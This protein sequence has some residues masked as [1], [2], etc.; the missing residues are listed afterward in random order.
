MDILLEL[1]TTFWQWSVVIVLILIGFIISWFDGQG[2][3]CRFKN[4]L[5]MPYYNL[6]Q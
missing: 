5:G 4:A 2:E 6:Y 3:Q 1:A